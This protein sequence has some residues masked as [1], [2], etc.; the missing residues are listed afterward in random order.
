MGPRNSQVGLS[1]F[2][3]REKPPPLELTPEIASWRSI[4]AGSSV[5]AD[6]EVGVHVVGHLVPKRL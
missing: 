5:G 1:V 6:V 2:V 4:T 3:D